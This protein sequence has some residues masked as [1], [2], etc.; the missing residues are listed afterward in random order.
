MAPIR[1]RRCGGF[2]VGYFDYIYSCA[3]LAIMW[4]ILTMF[5]NNRKYFEIIVLLSGS[6]KF[7]Y[8]SAMRFTFCQE[9]QVPSFHIAFPVRCL[10]TCNS[11][12][13]L[14]FLMAWPRYSSLRVV[15]LL[16]Y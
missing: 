5:T 16:L 2:H 11:E 13:R 12:Y 1:F 6:T 9:C 4:G 10:V 15:M 7:S 3:T 14:S 8:S